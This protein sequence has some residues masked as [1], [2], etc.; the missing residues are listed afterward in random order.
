MAGTTTT[1]EQVGEAVRINANARLRALKLSLHFLS[2]LSL[3]MIVL[4]RR[5]PRYVPGEVRSGVGPSPK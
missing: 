3:L 5:L 4:S 2:A 1:T